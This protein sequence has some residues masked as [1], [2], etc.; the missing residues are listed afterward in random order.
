MMYNEIFSSE[1]RN[2]EGSWNY[3]KLIENIDSKYSLEFFEKGGI[4]TSEIRDKIG[5]KSHAKIMSECLQK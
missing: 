1:N 4:Y 3:R 5:S 2:F